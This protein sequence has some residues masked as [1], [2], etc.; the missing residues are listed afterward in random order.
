MAVVEY[1]PGSTFPGVIGRTTDESTPAWPAPPRQAKGTPNVVLVVLDDTGF[2]QFR[3]F[4]APP[5]QPCRPAR[6]QPSPIV[7][8]ERRSALDSE[9]R[10]WNV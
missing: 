3:A 8:D 9:S 6:A 2:G 1:P 10:L 4:A 5:L 7:G